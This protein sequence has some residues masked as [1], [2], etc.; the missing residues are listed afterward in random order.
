MGFSF[1][2][3]WSYWKEIAIF[4][5]GVVIYSVFIF[6]FYRFVARKDVFP[7]DLNQ[8]NN[9]THDFWEKFLRVLFYVLEYL[10]IFPFFVFVWF[11]GLSVLV[12]LM[13]NEVTNELMLIGIAVVGAIRICAYYDEDLAKDLAKLLPFALLG[14]F[15]VNTSNFT[16]VPLMDLPSTALQ[17]ANILVYYFVF[18]IFLEFVLRVWHFLS[19]ESPEELETDKSVFSKN[20]RE[21]KLNDIFNKKI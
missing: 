17:N 7:L 3:G 18:V 15:V 19:Y 6:R 21:S 5:F 2:V 11:A 10:I 8:Y 20:L 12:T 14:A 13:A 1:E 9:A 16:Y 4:I